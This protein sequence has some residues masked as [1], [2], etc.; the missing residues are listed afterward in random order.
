MSNDTTEARL[1]IT[2]AGEP[3]GDS[4][5]SPMTFRRAIALTAAASL[6]IGIVV[7]PII[8]NH[9]ASAADPTA[10]P[11]HL[12]SVSGTGTVS[13]KPDVADVTLGITVS[14]P[15]AKDARAAAATAMEAVIAAVKA[16]GVADK[17]IATVNVSLSPNY[18]YGSGSSVPRLVGY[19]FSNTVRVTVRDLNKVAAVVDD[20]VTAGATNVAGISFRVNDPTAVQAQA[21]Q[22]AM[23]AARTNANAL[24]QAAGVSIKGVAS[25][26]EVASSPINYYPSYAAGVA[27]D[28]ASTPIQ[29][30]T[31]DITVQVSVSYLI[32]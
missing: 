16:D 22:L 18:D 32:G 5:S 17:D 13:V 20:S 11:E 14:K 9:P 23:A 10:T 2:P 3:R 4:H 25:I 24:A 30:G 31:T 19:Q 8:A 29:T 12:I 21:R 7:G 28:S 1:A 6:L 26:S 15:T 27:K